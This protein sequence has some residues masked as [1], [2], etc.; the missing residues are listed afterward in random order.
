[1]IGFRKYS[2]FIS[3][4][5]CLIFICMMLMVT[6]DLMPQEPVANSNFNEI[7]IDTR[8]EELQRYFGYELLL[9]RYLSVPFD[10][11][12]NNN[13]Y[14]N[15]LDIGFL[16]LIFIPVLILMLSTSKPIRF[17]VSLLT[18]IL[19][20][21]FGMSNS[22]I[23]SKSKSKVNTD[24]HTINSYLNEVSLSQETYAVIDANI[25]KVSLVLYK[26]FKFVGE[27]VSGNKDYVTYPII[28]GL[29]FLLIIWLLPKTEKR[30]I[31]N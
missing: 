21:I 6:S 17:G 11:T 7:V 27:S 26:P 5:K 15:F 16:F 28:L 22:Y 12:M 10:I 19:L 1:M 18:F 30:H 2:S 20:F 3:V 29:L 24:L 9:Y 14:G 25:A 13:Q 8:R 23:L 31:I 4:K